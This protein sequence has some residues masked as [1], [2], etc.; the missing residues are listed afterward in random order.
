MADRT[1]REIAAIFGHAPSWAHRVW[2]SAAQQLL[3]SLARRAR[4]PKTPRPVC[5]A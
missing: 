5:A 1:L 2:E 3:A 4:K